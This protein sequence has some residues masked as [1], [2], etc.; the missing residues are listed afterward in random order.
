MGRRYSQERKQARAG[1]LFAS[2]VILGLIVWVIVPMAGVSLISF[3][4]WN[5]LTTPA[6]VGLGNYVKL[7]TSDLYF[8]NTLGV[9]VLFVALNV[10]LSI[11]FSLVV[12]ILLNQRIVGR[13]FFRTMFYLPS[14]VP[15]VASSALWLWLYNPDFG[16]F[17][18]ILQGLGLHRG[19]WLSSQ[20]TV[21]PSIVIMNVWGTA[22]NIIVI[23][24]AALQGV[25]RQ[26]LEAVEIDGGNWWHRFTAV[27]IPMISPVIFFNVVTG[28]I[29]SFSVFT[30]AY[31]M[32]NGGPNNASLFYV[33]LLYR[34]GFQRN[35]FGGAA[36][37]SVV[38]FVLVTVIGLLLFRTSRRWVYMEGGEN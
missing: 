6:W 20:A 27:T 13:G 24:L 9:T 3:T 4:N 30:Q 19:M 35:N 17:N 32:T 8:W 10:A 18:V 31:V 11:V 25:P 28:V 22:G 26:L 34:E 7:F 21:V 16:L 29:N 5:V 38:L 33:V 36:A 23:F 14:I 1:L 15:V 37:L 12:A 2:P